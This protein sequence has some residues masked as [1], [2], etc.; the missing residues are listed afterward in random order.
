MGQSP[1]DIVLFLGAGF[2]RDAGLPT[3]GSFG[4]NSCDEFRALH[5]QAKSRKRN[6]LSTE[7]LLDAGRVFKGMQKFCRQGSGR[8][9]I[10]PKNMEEVFCVAEAL[11]ESLI[12]PRLFTQFVRQDRPCRMG[13]K[14]ALPAG[15][16]VKSIQFWLWNIYQGFPPLNDTLPVKRRK[17]LQAHAESYKGFFKYL[18]Q[19]GLVPRTVVITTNYDLVVEYYSWKAS[20]QTFYP[21]E[22][23][24][25]FTTIQAGPN[26]L[27]PY[28]NTL[29]RARP[30][31]DP[32]RILEVC[33]LHGSVNYFELSDGR[34]AISDDVAYP[35]ARIGLSP[36]PPGDTRPALLAQDAIWVLREKYDP[37]LTP[38]IVPPTYAKLQGQSWLRKIWNRAFKAICDAKLILFIGYSLPASDGFMRAMFQG[39]L[40]SREDE[41]PDICVVDPFKCKAGKASREA[42]E[43]LFP[44]LKEPSKHGP[45]RMIEKTFAEAWKGGCI[46]NILQQY[47]DN[48]RKH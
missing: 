14:L 11:A 1:R 12:D 35:G 24:V 41:G 33:K 40:A 32:R 48:A 20:K 30:K 38:A 22:E 21:L 19:D 7:M 29:S 18:A 10:D 17:K 16:V 46:E 13:G 45:S 9:R 44:K 25:D 27:A 37:G 43:N 23:G 26:T 42:Y 5:A 3:M 28:V 47:A 4:K 31:E 34:L 15:H 2:S 8:V 39:A 36:I 6:R